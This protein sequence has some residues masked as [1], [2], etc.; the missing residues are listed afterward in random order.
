MNTWLVGSHQGLYESRDG[1][2]WKRVHDYD[3]RITS[4]VRTPQKVCVSTGS[5]LWQISEQPLWIQLHDETLTEVLDL[6]FLPGDPGIVAASTYGVATGYREKNGVVRWVWHSDRLPVNARYTNTVVAETAN[7]WVIGTEA[8][9]L[10]TEDAGKTWQHSNLMGC[11]V[12]VLYCDDQGWWA[13][14]DGR[15]IWTSCDGLRWQ[16]SGVGLDGVTIYDIAPAGKRL[17]AGT[18]RGVVVGHGNDAWLEVGL[19]TFVAAVAAHPQH[20]DFW[21]AGCLPGG[22]WVTHSGGAEWQQVAGMS[23]VEVILPPEGMA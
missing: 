16:P 13:G 5:G 6:A 23:N 18:D 11:A 7:R 3:F 22:L 10:V 20:P 21:M 4:I 1:D 15:G 2:S 19:H 14:T 8:G 9:V 12:R 17:I